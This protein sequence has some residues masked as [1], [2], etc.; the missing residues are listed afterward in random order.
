MRIQRELLDRIA[1]KIVAALIEADYLVWEDRPEKLEAI[2]NDVIT[3]DLMIEDQLNEEVRL[4]IES[5][6]KE[7]ERDMM[8]YGRVFQM[9]K[10]KLARERGLIL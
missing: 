3:E 9:V 6:T 4:L 7:Y 2:V 1:K 8:D 10:S 5:R